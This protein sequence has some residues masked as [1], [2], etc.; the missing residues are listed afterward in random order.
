MIFALYDKA[1][2][3]LLLFMILLLIREA[4]GLIKFFRLR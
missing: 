1:I 3:S 2:I 4:I